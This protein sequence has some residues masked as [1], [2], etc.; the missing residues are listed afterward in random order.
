MHSRLVHCV[1]SLAMSRVGWMVTHIV[2]C[3]PLSSDCSSECRAGRQRL[4]VG[5]DRQGGACRRVPAG[6]DRAHV[7]YWFGLAGDKAGVHVAADS[8][9]VVLRDPEAVQSVVAQLD[10][11]GLRERGLQASLS[12]AMDTMAAQV[13]KDRRS[14]AA[15]SKVRAASRCS[16]A[17][18]PADLCMCSPT[19]SRNDM[20]AVRPSLSASVYECDAA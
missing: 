19:R 14:S 2:T 10:E 13:A 17:L 5:T 9:T 4:R 16:L 20:G 3:G 15:T 7:Q 8:S 1:H 11:R 12:R 18:L 6:L